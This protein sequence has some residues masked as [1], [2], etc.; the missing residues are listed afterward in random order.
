KSATIKLL[1]FEREKIV[2]S[3]D[4][5]GA[6]HIVKIAFHPRWQLTGKGKIYLAAPGYLLVVPETTRVEL[7]YGTTAIGRWGISTSFFAVCIVVLQL[8]IT[9]KPDW[10]ERTRSAGANLLTQLL[11][12]TQMNSQAQQRGLSPAMG[13]ALLIW[14]AL[15]AGIN[16]EAYENNPERYYRSAWQ[17]MR[18]QDYKLASIDFDSIEGRRSSPAAQEEALFWAAKAHE[19]AGNRSAAK[20]RYQKLADQYTGRWL[21]ESLY[22]LAR[23]QRLDNQTGAALVLELRL[24][25]DYPQHRYTRALNQQ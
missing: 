2:F 12:L 15:L 22:T 11:Q 17:A 7:V 16:F 3:T 21:P 18:R 24:R 23:L 4:Q 5:P 14:L 10:A 9:I 20:Q 6:A 19:L 1:N 13:K 25:S 8:L